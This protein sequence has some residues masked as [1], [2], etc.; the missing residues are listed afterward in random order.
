MRPNSTTWHTDKIL[1]AS[2]EPPYL[3]FFLAH[4]SV[5]RVMVITKWALFLL[6]IAK[7][8]LT[9][10]SVNRKSVKRTI[11]LVWENMVVIVNYWL[12]VMRFDLVNCNM[13]DYGLASWLTASEN[14][15]GNSYKSI[16]VLIVVLYSIS[17]DL[18]V[19]ILWETWGYLCLGGSTR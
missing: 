2:L 3:G 17:R 11:G 7:V 18:R 12:S 19:W 16:G 13:F 1:Y 6:G 4:A 8:W 10:N 14:L 5:I 9:E 15:S